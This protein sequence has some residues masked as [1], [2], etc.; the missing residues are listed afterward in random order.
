MSLGI[1][2]QDA[3][4]LSDRRGCCSEVCGKKGVAKKRAFSTPECHQVASH[5]RS[6]AYLPVSAVGRYSSLSRKKAR[7]QLHTHSTS[8]AMHVQNLL[9]FVIVAL[10]SI[11]GTAYADPDAERGGGFS[12]GSFG[13]SSQGGGGSGGGPSAGQEVP[14]PQNIGQALGS[15]G[16]T[17]HGPGGGRMAK[18]WQA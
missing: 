7:A 11:S 14:L 1:Y 13:G 6:R 9:S 5:H 8:L 17:S 15:G 12:G 3:Q 10:L 16:Y 4:N 18:R 2:E